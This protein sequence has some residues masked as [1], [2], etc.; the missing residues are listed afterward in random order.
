MD[1]AIRPKF[2][3]SSR[4]R[5]LLAISVMDYLQAGCLSWQQCERKMEKIKAM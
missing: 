1:G 2:S 3:S 4:R 5:E